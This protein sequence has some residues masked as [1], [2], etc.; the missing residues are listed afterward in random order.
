VRKLAGKAAESAKQTSALIETNARR[1]AG[2]IK[3]VQGV[4][5]K[6]RNVAKISR[7]NAAFIEKIN[8]ASSRQ[9]GAV[10]NVADGLES[11]NGLIQNN[12]ATSMEVANQSQVMS[13]NAASLQEVVHRFKLGNE[14]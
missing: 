1:T 8:D 4:N 10:Q 3:I 5:E 11:M 14:K 13:T 12:T 9:K 7:D 2:G 6:L